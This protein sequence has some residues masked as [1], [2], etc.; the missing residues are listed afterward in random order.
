MRKDKSKSKI[1]KSELYVL[2]KLILVYFITRLG[3]IVEPLAHSK[4][5]ADTTICSLISQLR[6]KLRVFKWFPTPFSYLL[7]SFTNIRHIDSPHTLCKF[8][9]NISIIR[10][11]RI[12]AGYY[13][14]FTLTLKTPEISHHLH[15]EAIWMTF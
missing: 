11:V 10:Y 15:S 8:K 12:V 7:L 9:Y 14:M 2:H 13:R 5:S 6:G 3:V 4:G 1:Q